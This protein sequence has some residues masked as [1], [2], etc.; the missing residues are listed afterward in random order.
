MLKKLIKVRLFT[1][2]NCLNFLTFTGML[3]LDPYNC[4]LSKES[5]GEIKTVDFDSKRGIVELLRVV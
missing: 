5:V 3:C 4:L 2:K 1:F